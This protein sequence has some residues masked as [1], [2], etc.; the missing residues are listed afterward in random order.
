MTTTQ[1]I[2]GT[3]V[4]LAAA[5][6]AGTCSAEDVV[7]AALDRIAVRDPALAAFQTVRAVAALAEARAVDGR[8][9]RDALPLAGVPVAIKDI[10]A[11]SGEVMHGGSAALPRD[12]ATLDHP[13]VARLREAGA[14]VVGTTRTPELCLWSATDSPEVVTG[15]PWS[16]EVTCGGSS[17]GSAAAVAAGMVPVAHATD[18]LGSIRLPAAACGLVGI[19]P[20][21]GVVPGQLGR[22][23]WFGMSANGPL[24]TTVGDAA[25][26]L[27]VMA[28][29]PTL[30]QVRVPERAMRVAASVRPPLAGVTV[31]EPS[32]RAAFAVTALLRDAGHV[33]ERADPQYPQRMGLATT[34]R[35]LAAAADDAD[36]V[37]DQ[38]LLQPRSRIHAALGRRVR[39]FVTPGASDDFVRRSTEFFQQFDVLVTPTFADRP[40][41]ALAWSEKSWLAN[42]VANLRATGGFPAAWNLAGFPALSLPFGT[43]PQTGGPIGV[44][45]VAAPGGEALLLGMAAIIERLAPWPRTAPGYE[46]G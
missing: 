43:D 13:V 12:A 2:E 20:G 28:A 9:D 24:A 18:G 1:R 11:V 30:A 26:V 36:E 38:E 5:V 19:K 44:Q 46:V 35:W 23:D 33:I 14:V 8:D 21:T 37:V 10:V 22:N 16:T 34:I 17:G 27:S 29:D 45:L 42:V 40:L 7:G 39:G 6:R 15:N 32:I 31:S 4:E 41:P 3:A 25:L